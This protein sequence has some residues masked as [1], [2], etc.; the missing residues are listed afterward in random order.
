MGNHDS[1]DDTSDRVPE[2]LPDLSDPSTS[3]LPGEEEALQRR[4]RVEKLFAPS[5]NLPQTNK[6]DATGIE[7]DNSNA[8]SDRIGP[9][10]PNHLLVS[11]KPSGRSPSDS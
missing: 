6:S 9:R 7:G 2:A 3:I 1:K 11:K 8:A 10:T 4:R 5:Q